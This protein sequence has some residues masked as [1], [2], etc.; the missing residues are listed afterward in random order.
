M[1]YNEQSRSFNITTNSDE[2]N[3]SDIIRD[4]KNI[5]QNKLQRKYKLLMRA[6][7]NGY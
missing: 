6:G 1:G 4:F 5:H 7:V 2:G 3:I